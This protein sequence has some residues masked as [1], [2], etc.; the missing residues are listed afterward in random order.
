MMSSGNTG[1][2]LLQ[3][4]KEICRLSH[5]PLRKIIM[6]PTK[7]KNPI[8]LTSFFP[9]HHYQNDHHKIKQYQ[10]RLIICLSFKR[11]AKEYI[12]HFI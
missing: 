2:A 9:S 10:T 3:C 1:E 12:Q 4:K 6:I 7:K 11:L 5:C 8:A